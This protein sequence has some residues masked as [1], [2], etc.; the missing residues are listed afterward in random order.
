MKL[1]NILLLAGAALAVP[2]PVPIPEEGLT[3]TSPNPVFVVSHS[4]LPA[5]T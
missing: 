2:N 1:L 4:I 3:F 5:L